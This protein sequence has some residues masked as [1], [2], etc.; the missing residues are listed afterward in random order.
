MIL[1]G[2]MTSTGGLLYSPPPGAPPPSLRGSLYFDAGL[3]A[4]LTL[5]SPG[6]VLGTGAFTIEGW[7]YYNGDITDYG[8]FYAQP[9]VGTGNTN[10]LSL[11]TTDTY[12]ITLDRYGGN[13]GINYS[14][15][16]NTLQVATWHYII[17]NRNPSGLETMYIG[18]LGSPGS[19]VTCY[20][21]NFAAGNF[22]PNDY[23]AGT[24]VDSYDWSG[25]IAGI[26]N[27]YGGIWNGK[28]TNLRITVDSAKYDSNNSTVLAP[29]AEL[30]SDAYTRYLMLGDSVT[31]D[32]SGT[33]TVNN[34]EVTLNASKPF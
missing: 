1:S 22:D 5:Y 10:G 30:T 33:Q 21:A 26:G 29:S 6:V 19:P 24:C 20:R 23:A 27:Y 14:W 17:L 4:Y 7:F 8:D 11:F 28:M 18:T 9:I 32:A 12:N 13:G 31:T 2:G 25:A 3:A 16:P 34:Y 15:S